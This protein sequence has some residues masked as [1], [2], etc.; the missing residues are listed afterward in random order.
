[1]T[2]RGRSNGQGLV[3]DT[4]WRGVDF[5]GLTL[6]LGVG[7]GR[8]VAL[9]NE[10][11]A[12][13]LGTLMVLDREITQ[14]RELVPLRE[15]GPI[16]PVC[17]RP[18]Q[19]PVLREVVDLLVV[20][21]VLRRI[22]GP[23]L[24]VMFEEMWRALVPGGRLRISDV[25]EPSEAQYNTAWAERNRIVRKLGRILGRSVALSANLKDAARAL[26]SVGFENLSVSILPGHSLT[27]DWLEE[28]VN[29]VR[30]M[31]VG[32]AD[33]RVRGE[34]LDQDLACLIRAYAQGEQRGA[35][36]FVLQGRKPGHLALDME[37]S[38]T[39]EDLLGPAD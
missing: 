13:S 32:L 10:Q 5:S 7:T 36:R 39:E 33:R 14:L 24:E 15:H 28:T 34:I 30:S 6:V 16:T 29:A 23:K 38:F 20:N 1:M 31:A 8:L 26:G 19:L 25:I 18:G 12:A 2:R 35:E 11:V 17:G 4:V 27:D 3:T 22:P 9:L 21:A 37:A